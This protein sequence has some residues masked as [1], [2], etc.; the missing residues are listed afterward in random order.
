MRNT[1]YALAAVA[2]ALVLTGCKI[3]GGTCDQEGSKH[4]NADGSKYTCQKTDKGNL[5]A[6]DDPKNP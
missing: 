6:P 4:T 2:L 3:T 5:W 1:I